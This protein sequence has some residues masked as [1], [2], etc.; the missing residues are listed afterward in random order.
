[1][2]R[3]HLEDVR[4]RGEPLAGL[5]ASESLIYGRYGFGV[6]TENHAIEMDQSRVSIEGEGGSVRHVTTEEAIEVFPSV[7]GTERARR[8]GM[9]SRSALWWK[10]RFDDPKAD[11]GGFSSLRCVLHE[12]DGVPDGYAIYRQKSNWETGFPDGKILVR[13]LIAP[14]GTAHT[15]LWRY[16]TTIDLFPQIDYWNLPVDDPLVWK[17]PDHRRIKRKRWDALYL[18]ILDVVQALEARSYASDGIVR[19]DVDD[20]FFPAEGG[21][22]EL[23]VVGGVGSCRRVADAKAEVS[24][25]VAELASLY[26]GGNSAL[27]LAQAGRLRGAKEAMVLLDRMFRGD[28]APWCEEVF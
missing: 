25:G 1:M 12:T 14:S 8:P 15:G 6:A 21:R 17:V 19:F 4:R 24:L 22:F 9:L 26:L 16:L 5:W 7:Y 13:E 2:M 28:V 10:H 18:R 11:R 3:D 23:A 20:P 27:V